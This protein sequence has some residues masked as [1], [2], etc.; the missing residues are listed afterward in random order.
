[1]NSEQHSGAE[2]ELNKARIIWVLFTYRGTTATR[3]I[4][5]RP[6]LV[7]PVYSAAVWH[8]QH[9]LNCNMEEAVASKNWPHGCCYRIKDNKL[10]L[11]RVLPPPVQPWDHYSPPLERLTLPHAHV[12][13]SDGLPGGGNPAR[14][15]ERGY[16]RGHDG[17]GG[18]FGEI[19]MQSGRLPQTENHLETGRRA[20][21][22]RPGD[23]EGE[24]QRWEAA[25]GRM[26]GVTVLTPVIDSPGQSLFICC[27]ISCCWE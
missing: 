6:L 18:R 11:L 26:V 10:L 7:L 20:G 21:N 8:R 5:L 9:I 24:N 23:S 3:T 17:A 13:V 22:N 15:R 27:G 25:E 14:H 12:H 1:M 2:Q 4:P 19:Y 16:V